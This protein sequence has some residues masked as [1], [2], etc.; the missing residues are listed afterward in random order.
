MILRCTTMKAISATEALFSRLDA[1]VHVRTT[2][3]STDP[4]EPAVTDGVRRKHL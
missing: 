1:G 2:I 4:R 3:S